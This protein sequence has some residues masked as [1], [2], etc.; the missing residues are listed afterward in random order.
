MTATS[1]NQQVFLRNATG[2]VRSGRPID[3]WIFGVMAIGLGLGIATTYT[4]GPATFPGASIPLAIGIFTIIALFKDLTYSQL[5]TAMP[6][7][8]S[9]YVFQA[10]VL[11]FMRPWAVGN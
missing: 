6:R 10:R 9:E 5:G 11:D 1:D 2:L 3:A 4:L 7:S 8:G